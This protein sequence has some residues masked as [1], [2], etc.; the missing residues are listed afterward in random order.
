[1]W[2]RDDEV[3]VRGR[4]GAPVH[5]KGYL[6]DVTVGHGNRMR[7]E[8]LAGVLALAAEEIAPDQLIAKATELLA[9]ALGDI[10]ATFVEILPGPTLRPRY[11]TSP[12]GLPGRC[13]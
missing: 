4:D 12:A 6:Q 3:V 13:R 1:M 2:V 11:T 7:L 10:V 5:V 8:L 9:A